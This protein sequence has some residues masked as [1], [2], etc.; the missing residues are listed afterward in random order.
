MESS[1]EGQRLLDQ[2]NANPSSYRLLQAGLRQ[3]DQVADV[4]CGSGA[5]MPAILDIVG[6]QGSVTGVDLSPE[7]V[8]EARRLM[9]DAPNAEVK[10]GALPATGLADASFDFTWSQFVFEYLR[11]PALALRELIRVTRPG[12]RVAVADVDGIGLAFWPRPQVLEDGTEPFM[13]ALSSTGFDFFIG[14]KLFTLFRQAGLE[15]VQVHLSSLY[16]SAGA[17]ARLV[18]DYTQRFQVLAPI[19]IQTFGDEQRYRQ[20]ADAYLAM[21][22]DPDA[23]KYAV[24]LTVVGRRPP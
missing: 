9:A 22:G 17:D 8:K 18:A 19:A 23:L 5:V 24:V 12:G 1:K 7:R 15:D 3:G 10:V 13:R 21:L 11:Q 16:V 2:E 6:A 20:F 14:R 4:G